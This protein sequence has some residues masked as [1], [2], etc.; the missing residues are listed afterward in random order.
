[1]LK[2]VHTMIAFSRVKPKSITGEES[3]DNR[4]AALKVSG[5]HCT[6]QIMRKEEAV[7]QRER[8]RERERERQT[9]RQTERERER[10]RDRQTDRQRE[11]ERERERCTGH[12]YG[13]GTG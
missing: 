3:L 4:V 8:E 7:P 12:S 13:T 11:R 6:G 2:S 5:L 9:D 10:E 1:M